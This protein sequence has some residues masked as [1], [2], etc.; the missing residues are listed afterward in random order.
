MIEL[1]S[2]EKLGQIILTSERAEEVTNFFQK[3]R[4]EFYEDVSLQDILNFAELHPSLFDNLMK[5]VK[6]NFA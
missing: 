6:K 5:V 3:Y 2:M 4:K 1:R